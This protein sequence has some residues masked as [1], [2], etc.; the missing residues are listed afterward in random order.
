MVSVLTFAGVEDED[1]DED[2]AVVEG[3]I[4]GFEERRMGGW[5]GVEGKEEGGRMKGER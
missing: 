1:E 4:G 2:G 5:V 3:G